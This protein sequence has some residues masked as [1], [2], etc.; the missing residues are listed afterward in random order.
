MPQLHN[1]TDRELNL[2]ALQ[3]ILPAGGSIDITDDEA[4]GFAGHPLID[5]VISSAPAEVPEPEPP[6]A[7]AEPEH[8]EPPP[9][10]TE[11]E[12]AAPEGNPQ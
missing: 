6:E 12:P 1:R 9:D 8:V 11:A 4:A 7:P 3:R 2:W 5:V 10:H